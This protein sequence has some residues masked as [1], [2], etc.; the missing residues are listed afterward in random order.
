MQFEFFQAVWFFW[1]LPI[2]ILIF[3]FRDKTR[4]D[5]LYQFIARQ[6]L[7]TRLPEYFA[8]ASWLKLICFLSALIFLGIAL[9]KPY[10]GFEKYEIKRKGVDLYFL[11]DVSP[12]MNAE[13][14][15]PSRLDRARY[16][17]KDFLKALTGDRVGL[18]G[19]S[20]EAF[21]LVPLTGD[22]G[23]FDLFLDELDTDLIP[24]P[25]TNIKG[26]M[27][28]AVQAFKTQ[29][30]A[31][32]KAI[33]LISDGEDSIGLD[34]SMIADI[35]KHDIKVFVI[36]IGTPEGAPIPLPEGGYKR[37]NDEVILSRLNESALQDLARATGGGYV[38]SVSGDLDLNQIY[39]GGIK[40]SFKDA[41]YGTA[42]KKLPRYRFQWALIL[43]F[44]LLI[45]EALIPKKK[46]FAKRVHSLRNVVL[47]LIYS[48]ALLGLPQWALAKNP[49]AFGQAGKSFERGEYEKALD[50][51]LKLKQDN[52][53][54]PEIDYNLGETYYRLEKYDEAEGAFERALNIPDK[55]RRKETLYNLGNA[56]YR[57]NKL[58]E[59]LSYYEK[60]LQMDPDY[61]KAKLNSEFV[62]RQKQKEEEQKKE[63]Q[64]KEDQKKEENKEDEKQEQQEKDP[65]QKQEEQNQKED[66][67][68]SEQKENQ[69]KKEQK[70]QDQKSQQ[71]EQEEKKQEQEQGKPEEQKSKEPQ[72]SVPTQAQTS[73]TGSADK[74][75]HQWLQSLSDNPGQALKYLIEKKSLE[76]P[77]RFDKDW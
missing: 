74:N 76:N 3:V 34:E 25:G 8:A 58:E 16:E 32:S 66:Q 70:E 18:I 35:R 47:F 75:P 15:K 50:S 63:E 71:K 14:V 38:R 20:G 65:S 49:I 60:A 37:Q 29:K 5:A 55:K 67:E 27:E 57:Q 22:Y 1:S 51:Y 77:K 2:L 61:E 31:S 73:E 64:K 42:E 30:Q 69:D 48:A 10:D 54:D 33:I 19:F 72:E 23:A 36:G 6:E 40:K 7:K 11:V 13:D 44:I 43:G 52:P 9:M 46:P 62:K 4:R 45:L 59:A 68:K 12:S 24:V 41:E 21:V 56:A 17:I 53:S 28:K 26:A 39:F